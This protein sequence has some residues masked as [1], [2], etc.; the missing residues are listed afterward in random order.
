MENYKKKTNKMRGDIRHK[1]KKWNKRERRKVERK[2]Y[3][4]KNMIERR[5]MAGKDIE[6][7][8]T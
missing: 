5:D 7:V 6:K 1:R 2:I 8:T 3:I 4:K